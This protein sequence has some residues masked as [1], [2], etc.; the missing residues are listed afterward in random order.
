MRGNARAEFSP[1]RNSPVLR[2]WEIPPLARLR[3]A[4]KFPIALAIRRF[5]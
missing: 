2:T 3:F 4:Y 5:A 1:L